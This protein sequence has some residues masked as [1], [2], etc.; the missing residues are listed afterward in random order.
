ML[1][2][3]PNILSY[4]SNIFAN[5]NYGTFSKGNLD[6]NIYDNILY[7]NTKGLFGNNNTNLFAEGSLNI[8]NLNDFQGKISIKDAKIINYWM[9]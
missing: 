7:F 3:T 9:S 6:L 2:S 4:I 5:T 1:N 8:K